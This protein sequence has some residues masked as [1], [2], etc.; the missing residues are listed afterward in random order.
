MRVALV[1]GGLS[2]LAPLSTDLYLPA[3]PG[4]G[5]ELSTTASTIQLTLTASLIGLGAGQLL[6]G[7]LSDAVGR[8]R[9][10]VVGMGLYVLASALC[11]VAPSVWLLVALRF[12]QGVAGAAGIVIARAIVRDV[13]EGVEAA[14]LL[15]LLTM[16]MGA[17][18]ILAPVVGGQLLHVTDWRGMFA[19]LAGLGVLLLLSVLRTLPE[20][21]EPARRTGT[22]LRQAL[23]TY[24][25]LLGD[26]AF[27]AHVLAFA[28]YFAAVF[29]Y[30]ASSPFI[31][32]RRFGVSPQVF[33]LLF[34][35]NACGFVSVSQLSRR[36]VR[37]TGPARL[38]RI[39]AGIGAC[40]GVAV[41]GTA[42][43]GAAIPMELA[44]FAM[45][46]GYGLVTPNAAALALDPHPDVAGAASGLIGLAQFLFGGAVAP[47][48]GLAGEEAV[49]PMAIVIAVALMIVPVALRLLA[50]SGRL[51]VAHP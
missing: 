50:P 6:V 3:L 20:T 38:L 30:I 24:R 1:L 43:A 15:A 41:L 36:L 44:L 14:R 17:A 4:A 37:R 31:F 29:A 34:A 2:M 42:L 45:M 33:G 48:V 47:L 27:S 8:R 28:L 11:A 51:A 12:L 39:G 18:P 49:L 19:V 5:S 21:L 23:R 10:L 25:R 13:H 40:S 32:E 26:S 22:G 46:C 9:P 7:P 35:L 16:I